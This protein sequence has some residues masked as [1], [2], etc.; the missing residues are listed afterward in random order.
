MVLY[1]ALKGRPSTFARLWRSREF[2]RFC[3]GRPQ[4]LVWR[5]QRPE[6]IT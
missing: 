4:T 2:F 1:G 6:A 3:E 5:R